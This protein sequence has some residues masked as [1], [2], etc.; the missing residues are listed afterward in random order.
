MRAAVSISICASAVCWTSL[1]KGATEAQRTAAIQKGLASLYSAQAP[2]G[3]WKTSGDEHASTGAAAMAFLSQRDKWGE[4][5]VRYQAAADRA[6]AWLV[7]TANTMTVM[8]R[9]DGISV[10]PGGV[11]SCLGV[12]WFGKGGST[13]AT[14]SI[15]PVIALYGAKAGPDAVATTSGPLSGMTWRQIGQG[16]SNALVVSQS[17]GAAGRRAGGWSPF[18]PG[19]GDSDMA[20][21]HWA[22]ASLF[23]TEWLGA[24]TPAFVRNDLKT[25]LTSV[26]NTAGAVCS[27]PGSDRCGVA[28]A[29][30]GLLA[31]RF[32]G[33]GA[34]S[35]EVQAALTVLNEKWRASE[36]TESYAGYGHP[37]TMWAAYRGLET[38]L[39][40]SD[41]ELRSSLPNCSA[42]AGV[43]TWYEDYSQWL[44]D[45]QR[46][47]GTWGGDSSWTDPVAAAFY[48]MLAG[49][50]RVP[51][52]PDQLPLVS[53]TPKQTQV[54]ATAA[55]SDPALTST[56]IPPSAQIAAPSAVRVPRLRLRRGIVGLAL[57]PGGDGIASIG[58]DNRI[59][60]WGTSNGQQRLLLSPAV[61][62]PTG[63][64]FSDSGNTITSV[65]RNSLVRLWNATSGAEI[66]KLAGHEQPIRT[67]AASP[68]GAFLAT[69]GEETRV[70][71]WN[72]ANKRLSR[73]LWGHT[74]F[75][76]AL[77]F[78]PDSRL[79]ASVDEDARLL[80]FDVAAGRLLFTMRGHS[81][82]LDAVAF[83]SDG[84]L[85]ASAGQDTS[86]RL[87]DPS[88]GLQ[89]RILRG[90]SA[91]IRALAFG[92]QGRLLASAGEDTRII[93]WNSATGAVSRE[94]TGSSGPVNAL[95][96]DPRGI[97]LAS[98][99]ETGEITL[100]SV[101]LGLKLLTIRVP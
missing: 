80:L 95:A 70:M 12:Y 49:E 59:R 48:I 101:L 41:T 67:V 22:V 33:Y 96:F 16:I 42:R 27:Q 77:A 99:T 86:I 17:T 34:Q 23:Y 7:S 84:T 78:S 50:T 6:V 15:A 60:I 64:V 87:W 91:P 5:D 97:F 58:S 8:S 37:Y 45:H 29:G 20:S 4:N 92:P 74:D 56:A 83:A 31:M 73:I 21:T 72:T 62:S 39:G 63:I 88:R 82:P 19:N 51:L 90:H 2:E 32:A 100:W 11:A 98:A 57:N 94:L 30:A 43:C 89:L 28:E 69:A 68:N 76:N 18:I 47:S 9:E 54:A 79:L 35:A 65:G 10:C 1:A 46:E 40:T 44:V 3:Y 66:A 53:H 61:G 26:Q 52:V 75:V 24:V 81:G 55:V 93:L 14:G 13:Y 38:T 71:L 25:W 85:L 36:E